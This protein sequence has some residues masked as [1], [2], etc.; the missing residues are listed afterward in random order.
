MIVKIFQNKEDTKELVLSFIVAKHPVTG[1]SFELQPT[2]KTHFEDLKTLI[3]KVMSNDYKETD[4]IKI[5]YER[6]LLPRP[7]SFV[8]M[9]FIAKVLE[10]SRDKNL[11]SKCVILDVKLCELGLI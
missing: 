8:Q 1:I 6:E 4:N 7:I 5:V 3:G 2:P 11:I 9:E 10:E